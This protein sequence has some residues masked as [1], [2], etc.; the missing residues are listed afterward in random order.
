MINIYLEGKLGRIFGK[1]W[2]L[3]VKS[4]IEAIR[5]ID[6]NLK[7]KLIKYLTEQGDK[8]YYKIALQKKNNII[9]K[10]EISNRS[11]K[12]DIYIIPTIKGANS[13]VGKLIAATLLAVIIIVSQQYEFLPELFG[14]LSAGTPVFMQMIVASLFIGG[15]SQLLA[16]NP[17]FNQ[18]SSTDQKQSS[19][20]QGNSAAI[21]Q[22]G[23]VPVAYGRVLIS[24]MPIS[25]SITSYN[26]AS[27]EASIGGVTS[28]EL[29]G[30]G[31][32]YYPAS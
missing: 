22:G 14:S 4:P 28:E 26:Q 17:N 6:I 32:Q 20:F 18:S 1:K 7:G 12:S 5:A 16:P 25:I 23:S 9:N 15:V 2:T 30:G 24:P 13:G 21:S 31:Y 19:Y 29:P 27:T 10:E 3:D 8:K 11:G